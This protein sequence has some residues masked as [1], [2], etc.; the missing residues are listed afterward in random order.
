MLRQ[1][2]FPEIRKN[3]FACNPCADMRRSF[4]AADFSLECGFF[5]YCH[6]LHIDIFFFYK[7]SGSS[8]IVFGAFKSGAIFVLLFSFITAFFL[9]KFYPHPIKA[10]SHGV[11]KE[12]FRLKG[13][14]NGGFEKA[15]PFELSNVILFKYEPID[16]AQIKNE[17][18]IVI[19][20]KRADS[21]SYFPYMI[22]LSKKGYSVYSADFF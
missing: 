13:T 2:V 21:I 19:P 3:R 5:F 22:L 14:F 16:K 12:T 15:L 9:I 7:F 18:I 20:D 11:K 10:S 1:N 17:K 6:S 8:Q 4:R